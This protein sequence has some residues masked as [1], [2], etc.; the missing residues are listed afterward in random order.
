MNTVSAFGV[1][2]KSE[3]APGKYAPVTQ[4]GPARL[5]ATR[6]L[7]AGRWLGRH[8]AN[9]PPAANTGGRGL[10]N[11]FAGA[12]YSKREGGGVAQRMKSEFDRSG[13]TPSE[14]HSK[15][16]YGSSVSPQARANIDRQIDPKQA[17]GLRHTVVIHHDSAL[18]NAHAAAVPAHVTTGGRG[19]IVLGETFTA[20]GRWTEAG[21]SGLN[22]R[23]VI[24][25]EMAHA[26]K[27]QP[28]HLARTPSQ[29]MG[30]EARADAVS[31]THAYT[32]TGAV[33]EKASLTA[34][35][36]TIRDAHRQVR[37]LRRTISPAERKGSGALFRSTSSQLKANKATLKPF[38]RY[39]QVLGLAGKAKI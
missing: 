34:S 17:G 14:M 19:H 37:R 28:P 31:G 24:S 13:H 38:L 5:H 25:H 32:K 4:M 2:H 10:T 7:A 6:G 27:K 1:V 35:S 3:S 33:P 22:S 36:D 20:G 26:A 15:I 18:K 21:T 23:S 9:Q 30:E 11:T 39:H 12:G 8:T 16:A 29:N